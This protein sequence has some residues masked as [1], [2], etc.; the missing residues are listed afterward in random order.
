MGRSKGGPS[1]LRPIRFRVLRQLHFKEYFVIVKCSRVMGVLL[2]GYCAFQLHGD[3][4]IRRSTDKC[5]FRCHQSNVRRVLPVYDYCRTLF[6]CLNCAQRFYYCALGS[7]RK[8]GGATEHL[9]DGSETHICR[10]SFEF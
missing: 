3:S 5:S 2:H 7:S 9:I 6:R 8:L 1:L 4:E 10:L